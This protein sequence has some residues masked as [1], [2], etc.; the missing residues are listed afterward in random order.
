MLYHT[1]KP[2]GQRITCHGCLCNSRVATSHVSLEFLSKLITTFWL[3]FVVLRSGPEISI[4][5]NSNAPKAGKWYVALLLKFGAA[6]EII[7]AAGHRSVHIAI[8]IR[9]IVLVLRGVIHTTLSGVTGERGM[10]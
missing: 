2:R 6:F 8:H 5:T 1:K 10:M 9:P 4:L 3:P 7:R